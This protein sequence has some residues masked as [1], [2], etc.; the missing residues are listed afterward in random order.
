TTTA[1]KATA[2]K[3]TAKKT[4]AKKATARK[5]ATSRSGNRRAA[6]GN[7]AAEGHAATK[8]SARTAGGAGQV[9]TTT[10]AARLP[11][12]NAV[13]KAQ[14]TPRGVNTPPVQDAPPRLPDALAANASPSHG[15]FVD[16]RAR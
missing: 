9:D 15:G 12:D 6:A 3:A 13:G 2:K 4:A 8:R 10:R 1:K 16:E 7:G 11:D 14:G 5:A